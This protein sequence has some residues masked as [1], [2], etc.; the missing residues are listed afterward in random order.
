MFRF[1]RIGFLGLLCAV[2]FAIPQ[3]SEAAAPIRVIVGPRV[4]VRPVIVRP[5]YRP[6]LPICVQPGCWR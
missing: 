3:A 1:L 2:P 5:V 4:V 6:G